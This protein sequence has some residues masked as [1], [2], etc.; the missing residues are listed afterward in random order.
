MATVTISGNEYQVYAD[1]ATADE[2]LNA[3]IAADDWRDADA[4]TKARAL[5]TSTR[6]IDGVCWIEAYDTFAERLAEPKFVQA[7]IDLASLL[8]SN[9]TLARDMTGGGAATSDGGTKRLKAGSVEIEYFY[10][11]TLLLFGSGTGQPFPPAI[12]SLLG[13][14]MCEDTSTSSAIA[15]SWSYD[16]CQPTAFNRGQ[17][18]YTEGF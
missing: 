14:F 9:P 15:G 2:R 12:M 6:W 8:V 5:V 1:V 3:D 18:G 11:G 7:S 4:D 10:K 16:T 13:E 17:F